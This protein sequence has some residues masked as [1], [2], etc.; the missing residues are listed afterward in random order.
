MPGLHVDDVRR[1]LVTVVQ[2]EFVNAKKSRMILGA[3]ELSVYNVKPFQPALVD[4]FHD[5]LSDTCELAD[6][7]VGERVAG[8]E[9][10]DIVLKLP[11]DGVIL[12]LERDF[13]HMRALAVHAEILDILETDDTGPVPDREVF[14]RSVETLIDMQVGLAAKRADALFGQRQFSV[15]A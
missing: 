14:Q 12:R 2:L 13:L 10:A 11:R 7:L 8:Q 15:H 5:V 9:K 1:V 4:G 6:L 3:A